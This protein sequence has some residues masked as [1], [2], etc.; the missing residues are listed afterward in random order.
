MAKKCKNKC[1]DGRCQTATECTS[2]TTAAPQFIPSALSASPTPAPVYAVI[3]NPA[4]AIKTHSTSFDELYAQYNG[5]RT[6]ARPLNGLQHTDNFPANVQ[7]KNV[8]IQYAVDGVDGEANISTV[9][10]VGELAP[11]IGVALRGL[12]DQIHQELL[13]LDQVTA[14]MKTAV[15]AA[16]NGP[17]SMPMPITLQ[18]PK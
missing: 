8:R 12:V 2:S 1:S 5:L 6:L 16:R 13:M 3:N 15:D 18:A 4:A 14:A 10:S 17:R 11:L 7:I 9:N